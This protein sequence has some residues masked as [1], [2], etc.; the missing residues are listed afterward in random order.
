M[1]YG[2]ALVQNKFTV[3]KGINDVICLI[4]NRRRLSYGGSI[5]SVTC[6]RVAMVI[7]CSW[8]QL[9]I[10]CWRSSSSSF[11]STV[12]LSSEVLCIIERALAPIRLQPCGGPRK[13]PKSKARW[14]EEE[15]FPSPGASYKGPGSAVSSPT[16]VRGDAPATWGFITFYRL[17]K[18]LLVSILLMLNLFQWNSRGSEPYRRPTQPN[19][20][21]VRTP[22]PPL[23][24]L[25]HSPDPYS[26][27]G[28]E[29][30]LD[31]YVEERKREKERKR[32]SAV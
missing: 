29:H 18:L 32:Q 26:W 19:F 1:S 8:H 3:C 15:M 23:G 11:C 9:T 14:S 12:I 27:R 10:D 16:G 20:V 4:T 31:P 24:S 13:W 30:L 2:C 17:T 21:G 28:G 7:E 22:G 5:I 25:Q 6:G